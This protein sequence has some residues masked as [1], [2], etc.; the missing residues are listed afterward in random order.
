MSAVSRQGETAFICWTEGRFVMAQ[1]LRYHFKEFNTEKN[2]HSFVILFQIF[3]SP[4]A[5][6]TEALPTTVTIILKVSL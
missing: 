4:V 2:A 5:L 1:L 3:N 6:P